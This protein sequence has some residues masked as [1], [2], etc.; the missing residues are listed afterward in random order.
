MGMIKGINRVIQLVAPGVYFDSAGDSVVITGDF[1]RPHLES[2][3]VN[4]EFGALTIKSAHIEL[5]PGRIQ[6]DL[7]FRVKYALLGKFDVP[8]AVLLVIENFEFN[9][10][11]QQARIRVDEVKVVGAAI[12]GRVLDFVIKQI[13]DLIAEKSGGIVSVRS[14]PLLHVELS[15]IPQLEKL[16]EKRFLGLQAVNLVKVGPVTVE[17]GQLRARVEL[18]PKKGTAGG[19]GGKGS[20]GGL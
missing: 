20:Q 16:M 6:L 13:K 8:V 12:P 7:C 2:A 5:V 19:E 14:W 9:S 18:L 4:K 15:R 3:L 1:I 17:T 11:L 10:H